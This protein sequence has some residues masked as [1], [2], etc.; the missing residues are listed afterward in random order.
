MIP[1][2]FVITTNYYE[3]MMSLSLKNIFG[4]NL[5]NCG[6]A[7]L[8]QID[9]ISPAS[10]TC[11]SIRVKL[12]PAEHSIHCR[13]VLRLPNTADHMFSGLKAIYL[14]RLCYLQV[15]FSDAHYLFSFIQLE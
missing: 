4:N 9:R 15:S 3:L 11:S 12:P 10:R 1:S 8:G 7:L 6:I 5:W 2:R 13:I 14:T